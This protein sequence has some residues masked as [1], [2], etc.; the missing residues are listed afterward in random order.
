MDGYFQTT[1]DAAYAALAV[2]G[3]TLAL[4]AGGFIVFGLARSIIKG[5]N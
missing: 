1:V 3:T 5:E 4:I 2:G